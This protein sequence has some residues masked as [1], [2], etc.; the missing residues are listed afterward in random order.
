MKKP[1]ILLIF[2]SFGLY[3]STLAQQTTAHGNDVNTPLHLLQ[4]NYPIPYGVPVKDS[5]V[6]TLDRIYNYLA[7]VTPPTL[8]DHKT[9]ELVS[10]YSKADSNTIFKPGDFR[11][12]SY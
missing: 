2:F 6:K 8:V 4:P 9:N 10:D 12:M 5:I 11:L 3:F 1:V 7:A